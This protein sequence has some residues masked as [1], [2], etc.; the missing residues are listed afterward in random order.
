MID[1][2][3]CNEPKQERKRMRSAGPGRNGLQFSIIG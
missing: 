2:D 1:G 3:K